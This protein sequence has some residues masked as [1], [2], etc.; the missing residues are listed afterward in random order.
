[1]KYLKKSKTEGKVRRTSLISGEPLLPAC[2]KSVNSIPSSRSS[3]NNT[4]RSLLSTISSK[5]SNSSKK[6][7]VITKS[8]FEIF[9]Q[10][11][12]DYFNYNKYTLKHQI[13]IFTSISLIV[14]GFFLITSI[15]WLL[16]RMY[17]ISESELIKEVEYV[18]FDNIET[19]AT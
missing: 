19:L 6:I 18:A 9:K 12:K 8:K 15:V 1:M 3:S 2:A 17:Q 7:N 14:V 16:S 5:V 11:A 10:K 4:E 13:M